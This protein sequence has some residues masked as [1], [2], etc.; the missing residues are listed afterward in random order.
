MKVRKQKDGEIGKLRNNLRKCQNE[1]TEAIQ[2][3]AK[4]TQHH[5]LSGAGW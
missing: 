4:S 5:G 3:M 2:C 1:L